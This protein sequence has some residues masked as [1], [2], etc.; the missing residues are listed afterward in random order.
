MKISIGQNVFLP[1][2]I[3]K[4]LG[5]N[6]LEAVKH[7]NENL[8]KCLDTNYEPLTPD[9]I[10]K[11][12][13]DQFSY[14]DKNGNNKSLINIKIGIANNRDE[15]AHH[16][17][18]AE[19]NTYTGHI[20]A[21]P[22]SVKYLGK[23]LEGYK[24]ILVHETTHMYEAMCFP[25][26]IHRSVKCAGH[27]TRLRFISSYYDNIIY[28]TEAEK[29]D[30]N[31]AKII[32]N[33]FSIGMKKQEKLDALQRMRYNL[34][35]EKLAYSEELKYIENHCTSKDVNEFTEMIDSFKIN[36]KLDFLKEE[37]LNLINKMRKK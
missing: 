18:N 8:I 20:I 37:I 23:L 24:H 3:I 2:K 10:K 22:K 19:N 33:L 5:N 17:L 1:P 27:L 9:R 21:L 15:I 11:I 29:F 36:E 14:I 28:N 32:W 34:L 4:T 7:L 35:S 26:K 31:S 12:L 30:K 25:K 16:C 6:R 13:A